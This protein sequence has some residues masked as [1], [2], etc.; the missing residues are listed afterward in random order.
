[1]KII[2]MP[3]DPRELPHFI[4]HMFFANSDPGSKESAALYKA[5]HAADI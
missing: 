2:T 3:H 1:M 4:H 5:V